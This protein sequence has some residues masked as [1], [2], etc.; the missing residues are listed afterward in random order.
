MCAYK[1]D[2]IG[3]YTFLTLFYAPAI[4]KL[5]LRDKNNKCLI[6]NVSHTFTKT[7]LVTKDI[8]P[9]YSLSRYSFNETEFT[10]NYE[11]VFTE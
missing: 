2:Y 9:N 11:M 3:A 8:Y 1:L 7:I 10:K 5:K 6:K 4:L